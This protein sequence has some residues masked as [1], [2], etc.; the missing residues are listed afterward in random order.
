MIES[1]VIPAI[2]AT[3]ELARGS[4]VA[5]G[6]VMWT[7]HQ[8]CGLKFSYS[9]SVKDWLAAPS[10]LE[11]QRVDQLV[12][13]VKAGSVPAMLRPELDSIDKGARPS[14]SLG[15][16]LELALEIIQKLGEELAASDDTLARHGDK[17]QY[18]DIAM[19]M[20]RVV[21]R[22]LKPGSS[23]REDVASLE[24]LRTACTRA[25]ASFQ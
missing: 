6:V 10:A 22:E 3:I 19:Q 18:L 15:G 25:A 2:G 9:V 7:S 1:Q 5:R 17:L 11:Q 21:T 8:R 4:L 20:L 24:S 13:L 14:D 16:D 23:G 12:A